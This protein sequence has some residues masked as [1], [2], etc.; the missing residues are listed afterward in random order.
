MVIN[1]RFIGVYLINIFSLKNHNVNPQS[2]MKYLNF[3]HDSSESVVIHESH[4]KVPVNST[5]YVFIV[6]VCS[7]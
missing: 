2:D 5:K 3:L 4:L 1:I 6:P 7:Q